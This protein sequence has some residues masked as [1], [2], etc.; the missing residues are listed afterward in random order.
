MSLLINFPHRSMHL[1]L[2]YAYFCSCECWHKQTFSTGNNFCISWKVW[3]TECQEAPTSSEGDRVRASQV[4]WER[5]V[6]QR[7]LLS[8]TRSLMWKSVYCLILGRLFK[9]R[10]TTLSNSRLTSVRKVMIWFAPRRFA[11]ETLAF[12]SGRSGHVVRFAWS[13]VTLKHQVFHEFSQGR[14][15]RV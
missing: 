8:Q 2:R 14:N 10:M 4:W 11:R 7:L 13:H 15:T 5:T 12:S 1:C 9:E 3:V 6:L